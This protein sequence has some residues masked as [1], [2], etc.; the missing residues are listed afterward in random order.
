MDQIFEKIESTDLRPIREI[1]LERLRKAIMDGSFEPGDRLVET[2]IAEGMGVSRTPV[3]EAF[4][5]LEIE[6][7][8]ENVPRKGTIVKGIS[9]RDILEIYEIREVL[10]GLAFRLACA[11]ISEARILGLKEMLLKM[12]QSIDNNDIKE[13]WRLHGEFHN[14]IMDFSNNQRLIDQMKQIYEYLSKL[15]NFT[16]VM[17]K[18]RIIAME[19]HKALIKAFENKDEILAEQIGRE[20]TLNAKRFLSKEIHL[21]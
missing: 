4:R 8:A 12:E 10:E 7:L 9:K 16:L 2:S 18:R 6:G 5:Q 19:E 14:T 3:R 20:H 15:R 13:Y 21:F 17:N 11:N 1:V